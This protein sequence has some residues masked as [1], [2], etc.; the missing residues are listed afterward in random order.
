MSWAEQLFKKLTLEEKVGQLIINR[1]LYDIDSMEEMLKNGLLGGVGAVVIRHVCKNDRMKLTEYLSKLYKISKIPP[2]MYLDAESGISDMFYDVGTPF[3]SQMAIAATKDSK[4]SYHVAKA[5]AKEAKLLGFDIIS[6]PVL[7]VNSNPDNPIIGTRSFGDDPDTVVRFGEEYING[8]QSERI[9]P[10]GKHFPGH[11]DT[12]VDSHIS[13]PVVNQSREML[14]RVELRPFRELMAKGMKGIMTAHIYYPA[15]QEGEEPGTPATL[16]RKIMTG[17]VKEEWGFEGLSITDSLTMRAI[18]DRYG[19][20]QAAVLAFK[21][22]ND[23]IL[24][25]YNS[26]PMITFKALLNAVQE[27]KIDMKELDAAVLKILKFKEWCLVHERKE[28]SQE[29]TEQLTCMNDHIALSKE[30][31][32]KSVTLLENTAIPLKAN[33]NGKKTLVI[34]TTSDA[35]LTAAKDMAVLITQKFYYFYNSVKRYAPGAELFLMSEDPTEEQITQI[36]EKCD[37]YD[38]IIYIT[39]VRILS[40]KKGSGTVPES[41]VRLL[42]FLKE[43][44][45]SVTAVIAGNPYA[46]SKLPVTDNL[47]CT[48]S[49]NVNTL[50][51]AADILFGVKKSVGKLPVNITEKYCSGY[52]L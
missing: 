50:D 25:D 38:E 37:K 11:G 19:T 44:N 16:S 2:F 7:D 6:N 32:D 45:C 8:M 51:T 14:D 36:A 4:M 24:Q 46:A 49:D 18:K 15:L 9:I 10:N 52:G 20:E 35:K 43:Q 3:P 17:L 22:G 47:L 29:T 48:Y 41:Q 26:D 34:A 13:M 33:D 12:S 23:M 28:I 1:G 42:S 27:G 31:A 21:A 39:F 40:Y 5:I 30:I